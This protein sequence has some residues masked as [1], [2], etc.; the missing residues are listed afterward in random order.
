MRKERGD[1][2]ELKINHDDTFSKFEKLK[3]P[4]QVLESDKD[5]L[6]L[7]NAITEGEKR[8]LERNIVKLEEQK[9]TADQ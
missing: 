6:I 8:Y 5:A 3:E 1:G 9:Y 2:Q 7:S 4:Y